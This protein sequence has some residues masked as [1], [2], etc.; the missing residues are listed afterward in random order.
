VLVVVGALVVVALVVGV[1]AAGLGPLVLRDGRRA[2]PRSGVGPLVLIA[3][4]GGVVVVALLGGGLLVGV[5]GRDDSGSDTRADS[6]PVPTSAPSAPSSTSTSTSVPATTVATSPASAVDPRLSPRSGSDVLGEHVLLRARRGDGREVDLTTQAV[7]ELRSDTVLQVRVEGFPEHATARASQCVGSACANPLPV[8]FDADGVASFQYLVSDDFLGTGAAACRL[9]DPS[10]TIVVETTDG[11]DRAELVTLFDDALPDPGRITV[12]P[13]REVLEGQLVT[14]EVDAFRP[15]VT[16]VATLCTAADRCR[17][18][19]GATVTVGSDG[20]GR[21]EVELPGCDGRRRCSLGVT[22][23]DGFARSDRVIL[24]FAAAPGAD[25]DARRLAA[26]LAIAIALLAAAAGVLRRSDW[27][28]IGE[29]A[30]PEIDEA[31]Y[32]DLDA[33]IAMLPPEED[34]VLGALA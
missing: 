33:I 29:E 17:R 22:S 3:G 4:V 31:E 2:E 23:D 24:T 30:A 12:V 32:A 15:G 7:G 8:Q 14:V 10:C 1:A 9:G 6:Q 11:D 27:S 34:D 20:R 28:P 5:G 13:Q 19:S 26:G 21:S 18:I 25:Y 16:L